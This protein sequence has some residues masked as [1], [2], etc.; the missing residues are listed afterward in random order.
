MSL[1]P[2]AFAWLG[3]HGRRVQP[4]EGV[5]GSLGHR[6]GI[7][8]GQPAVGHGMG[9]HVAHRLPL[10]SLLGLLLTKAVAEP[11]L[12]HGPKITRG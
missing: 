3:S 7:R 12:R 11:P 2:A 1:L 9:T 4:R 10:W 6:E 5:M 8:G